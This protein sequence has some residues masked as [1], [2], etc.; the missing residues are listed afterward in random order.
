MSTPTEITTFL[1]TT[2]M[3][4]GLFAAADFPSRTV[5]IPPGSKLL[6][7]TDGLTDGIAGEEPEERICQAIVE[8][9][10][11][12]SNLQTLVRPEFNEDDITM[13][14]LTRVVSE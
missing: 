9:G 6:F 13:L 3:S 1:K 14:L 11:T 2:G 5:L 12:I 10:P 7:F 8:P 4:L